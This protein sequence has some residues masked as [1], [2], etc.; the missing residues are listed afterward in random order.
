MR[1]SPRTFVAALA[2]V[3]MTSSLEAV[4][5]PRSPL[6]DKTYRHPGM[7]I[8]VDARTASDLPS[9][10]AARV[11]GDLATLGAP[12][13]T[14]YYDVRAG[15]LSSL[16]LREPMIPGTG[17]GNRLRWE[18]V[19]GEPGEAAVREAAWAALVGYLERHAAVLRVDVSELGT[20]RIAVHE[21]GTLVQV[22]SARTIGGIVVRDSGLTA[23]INH[24]N[25]VLLGLDRWGDA[26]ALASDAQVGLEQARS[27]VAQHAQPYA[28]ASFARDGGLEYL[29]MADGDGYA[30]RL[31]WSVR[32][33]VEGDGGSWE[34]LVD[35]ASGELLA[36]EDRN[37]YAARRAIGGVYP[38]SNDQ[39]PPDG[40]EQSGWPMPFLN[41]TT[42]GGVVT[43]NA[44][45][46]IGCATGTISTTLTGRYTTMV[47][48]CGA[49]NET[50]AAGDLD[51]GF[52]PT[53]TATDCQV[54]AGHSAGDTKASRTGMY[55]LT[56]INEQARGY[57]PANTWL[58]SSLTS[59]MNINQT[60]NAFWNGVSVNFYRDN[61][62]QC[63]NTGEIAA[64]FDHEWGHGMD[65]NG[66][67]PN[68]ANPGEGIAD[69]H[70]I[71]RLN[72][73]CM[74]RGFFKVGNCGG[75][76]DPC[77]NCSGIREVDWALRQSGQ[78]HGLPW[79][80]LNCGSGPAP[81]GG[82]VHCEGAVVGESG[83]DLF[84][85]DFRGFSGSVF[86]YDLHTALELTTR[87]F[88]LGSGPV[89][90]WFQCTNPFGGCLATGGYMNMLAADDDNGNIA[91]GT[92]HMTAIFS[93]FNRHN[94]ACATPGAVNSGCAGGPTSA[95]TVT[96]VPQDQ[97]VTLSWAAVPG[98]SRYYVYRTEGVNGADFGK[99][100]VGEVTGTTFL[101]TNLQNGRTY[102][103]SV[104]P[105]GANPSCF[106]LMSPPITVNP[107]VGANLAVRPSVT[108]A[109]TGGDNDGVLD[110]CETATIGFTVENTG[111]GTLT[112]V[113][114]V[115]V[116]PVSHPS[117]VVLT[118][119]PATVAASLA[120]CV[121]AT[122]SVD[123][124]A[125]G[126]AFNDTMQI[127]ID[128]TA[129]QIFPQVRSVLATITGTETD[130]QTVA[131]RTY[132]FNTGLDGWVVANGTFNRVDL[133][134]GNFY[135]ASSSCLDGQCDVA[136]SPIIR[137]TATSTLSLQQRY[138]TEIPTPIPYDRA[139]V[140]IFNTATG[141]RTVVIPN[142]GDLYDLAPGAAN[143][144]CDTTEQ[145]GWSA[146]TDPDC[147]AGAAFQTS[148]WTAAALNPGG[149]FT[150]VSARLSVNYGTD[151]AANGFG[152]HF[153]NVILTNFQEAVPDV[154]S[155]TC[156]GCSTITV[157]PGTIPA[158]TVG[159]PYSQTFS[160]SGGTGTVTWSVNGALP[161][162]ITLNPT[163]GVLSGTPTQVGSFPIVV[164]ATDSNGC[165]GSRSYTLVIGCQAITVNPATIPNGTAGQ[166]YSQAFSQTSGIG[167]ITW[168]VTG[169][170]P[171]GLTL[172]P[173][174]G[175]LSG[176]P[177]QIGS[178]P[179]TIRATDANGCFGT[180]SYTLV[181]D[182][183]GPFVPTAMTTTAGGNGVFE[184]GETAIVAP[185]WRNDTGAPAAV[186]GT[187][188]AFTGPGTATYTIVD[189]TADYGT[190]APGATASCSAT[191]NC[192]SFSVSNSPRP[193]LHW[194]STFTET[195]SNADTKS[196]TLH[197][198]NSFTDVP[199]TSPFYRFVETL[200][201]RGVTGGTGPTTYGP[202]ASTTREA[203]AVFVL[204]AKEG[205][206]YAPPACT[207]PVFNDVPAT[208]PFCRWIEELARRGVVSGC[209]GGNYCPTAAATR[210]AMSVF[211]LRTLDPA[212]NPP[213]C[214]T[215]VF[216]DVP[217]SSP[218][219]RWIEELVR[220]G[221][222]TGCGGGN[223]CPTA[224][225]S[226]EQ[227][228]VFL[229][230]TFGLTLYGL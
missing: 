63:R 119:L 181:I 46:T 14:A 28:I 42:P 157:G 34:G 90:Q 205:A 124:R 191:G 82:G 43:T 156:A 33:S 184:P 21:H 209:G 2:L 108:V 1:L 121:T 12:A 187:A 47:D 207:T 179:I 134:G 4:V 151:P 86:N 132:N 138:D 211:V 23:V 8:V 38:V 111:T 20:P 104:L 129:D 143:G 140:G 92:P 142:G 203:M 29:P 95:P 35:A 120:D 117:S 183:A 49:A 55:E 70:S 144:T 196:W 5:E 109:V 62:S 146:D 24:G 185:T 133:G 13:G 177:T 83:W 72:D 167:T 59:N 69:V 174:T 199:T 206:G 127:R 145:A 204:V 48:V 164:T 53:P 93:A 171:T 158:G 192:Y 194:D 224:D 98:A 87:L 75:Y 162:G 170:L 217:A 148:T 190:V 189:S 153:D 9:E 103:F 227:M 169:A 168:S 195:L 73:S 198:G 125:L 123:V 230:V 54:P 58:Q 135:L 216:A 160:Q 52:G 102:F 22:H 126:L 122:G 223:Y 116:A 7:H 215:P 45:G 163:T 218:F 76:G 172:N 139:N 173:T 200:L 105:V 136:R 202:T 84:A 214:T 161:A 178:F 74:A 60:C 229:T 85:R 56:R 186:T 27:V 61:G 25:L 166:P 81:C 175:V 17:V 141:V 221:V 210:E 100:K 26:P 180:R 44:G 101:D 149:V 112:N 51:L 36:F 213:A 32:A 30:Y 78:P 79:I 228:G 77:T 176:T 115:A 96:A 94:I 150:G 107:V 80:D 68:I 225:V 66:V 67:N 226:R 155:N 6:A 18:D 19:A 165:A 220:R 3:S 16:L 15:R 128:V 131:T 37:Q 41:V 114:V 99:V 147:T 110:N 113:R 39:Q 182:A 193:A 65:N 64:V 212:L 201:H 137:L 10:L 40:I 31:V 91:D 50:S 88:Y 219:C 89:T 222:V 71:L 152:F 154:Q 130:F 159:A 57:L 11:E 118:P 106:G 197:L 208:S 188:S 97:G